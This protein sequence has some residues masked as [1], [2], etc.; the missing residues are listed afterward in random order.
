MFV[1]VQWLE[2]TFNEC[3]FLHLLQMSPIIGERYKCKDCVEE[4]GFDLCESCH[5]A[6]AKIPG[7]FNQQHKPEHEFE[8]IQPTNISDFLFRLSSEQS[9]D[10]GSDAPEHM[11][12]AFGN[13]T[14]STGVQPDQGD[15]SQ[16]PEDIS[17]SL[18]LSV[19]VSLDQEDDSDD[20]SDNISSELT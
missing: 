16:E 4:I 18:I 17:P 2:N 8:I 20:P 13:L 6:P 15:D 7:R 3:K 11:D 5:N 14:L 12:D 19:D 9:D 1:Y 10:D